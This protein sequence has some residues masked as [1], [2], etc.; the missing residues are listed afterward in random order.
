MNSEDR[1]KALQSAPLD[2]WIALSEDESRV[3]AEGSSFE[4][5]AAKAEEKGVSDPVLLRTPEDWTPR[6]LWCCDFTGRG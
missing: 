4:E 6:V 1:L 3:V 2:R 5:A